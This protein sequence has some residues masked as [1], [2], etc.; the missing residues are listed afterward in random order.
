[1]EA[2]FNEAPDPMTT[3]KALE[4]SGWTEKAD[5][6][7]RH[8][9][10][11]T[12]Q[13]IGPLLDS[14]G[15]VDSRDVLDICC[16]TGDLASAG[17]ARGSHITGVDFAY[18]MIR[19]ARAKVP[20]AVFLCGDA[21]HLPFPSERFDAAVCSFGIWHLAEPD[22][23]IAEAARVLKPGGVFAYTTW[24]PPHQGWDMV[25]LLMKAVETHGSTD[26]G[27]PPAPPPFRFADEAEARKV[28]TGSGFG[29]I[30]IQRRVALW[31]GRT[32]EELLDVIDKAIVRAPMLIVAQSS[33]AR[34]AIRKAIKAGAEAMRVD[35]AIVMRWPYLLATACRA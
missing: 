9:A 15:P 13:A 17:I 14:I 32:G 22:R 26:V 31:R 1:M 7:D 5:A 35:G 27:L 30:E 19:I 29:Q 16:G 18:T 25:D 24:L 28:L 10:S 11:I 8:F 4:Q 34:D 20:D 2:S 21:E 6:Y 3:F 23:A 33:Q 12:R